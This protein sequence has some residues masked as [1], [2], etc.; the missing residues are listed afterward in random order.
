VKVRRVRHKAA[1]VEIPEAMLVRLRATG[2]L[3]GMSPSE[4][5]IAGCRLICAYAI[6]EV[7]PR[8]RPEKARGR[9]IEKCQVEKLVSALASSLGRKRAK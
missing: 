7:E 4:V 5:A 6:S 2:F 3:L 8:L 9:G 1:E